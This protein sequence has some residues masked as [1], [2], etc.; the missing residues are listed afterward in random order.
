MYHDLDEID[1]GYVA[2]HYAKRLL[3]ADRLKSLLSLGA[4]QKYA[5]LALGIN[6]PYGNYSAAEHGHGPKILENRSH[7]AVFKL[8]QKLS[9]IGDAKKM[10]DVIYNENIP[11]LKVA[12]GSE[13]AMLLQP[14]TH[15]V[16]NTRSIWSHLLIKHESP[17]KADEELKLYRQ[18]IQE[19]EMAYK[20]WC[21]IHA[22]MKDHLQMI[23]D[24]GAS[25]AQKQ[26]VNPGTHIFLWAD[27]VANA[28]YER[29]FGN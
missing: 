2:N 21:A 17:T 29:R 14:D 11:Y 13:I 27:A 25:I 16:A 7:K 26:G 22:E 23:A 3:V 19:S 18:G 28:L 4:D 5:E 20:M 12:V 8:A 10:L 15:W 24:G 6:D 9:D 1:Y